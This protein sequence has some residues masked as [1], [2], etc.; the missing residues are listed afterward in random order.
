MVK[1]PAGF[2]NTWHHHPCAHG[3]FVLEAPWS[4]IKALR[5]RQL[6]GFPA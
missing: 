3:M 1:Y 6:L 4:P 2:V 5:A